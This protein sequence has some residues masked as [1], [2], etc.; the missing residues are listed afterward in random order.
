MYVAGYVSGS[1]NGQTFSGSTDASLIKFDVNGNVLWA[2]LFGGYE[3]E[4]WLGTNL[5]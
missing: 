1:F 3:F 5:I 4:E 2:R